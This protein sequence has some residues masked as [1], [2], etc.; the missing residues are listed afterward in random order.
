ML[1]MVFAAKCDHPHLSG[2]C[3]SHTAP[4]P[5]LQAQAELHGEDSCMLQMALFM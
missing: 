3:Q 4:A 1:S 5:L 2:S